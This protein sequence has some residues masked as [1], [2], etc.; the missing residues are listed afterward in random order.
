MTLPIIENSDHSSCVIN[1]NNKSDPSLASHLV[2][3]A[4]NPLSVLL[5][6]ASLKIISQCKA[7][8]K[9]D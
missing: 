8:S 6:I 5:L 9:I 7:S 1:N 3:K 4:R 2:S